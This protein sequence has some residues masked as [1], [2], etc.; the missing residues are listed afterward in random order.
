MV[1]LANLWV[2][3]PCVGSGMALTTSLHGGGFQAPSP[4][5]GEG[6]GFAPSPCPQLGPQHPYLKQIGVHDNGKPRLVSQL[7]RACSLQRP[8]VFP[9]DPKISCS[10]IPSKIS[11]FPT[12][13]LEKPSTETGL[14]GQQ[15][16][17]SD[18]CS[19]PLPV[20]EYMPIIAH[21]ILR[22]ISLEQRVTA[23]DPARFVP[24]KRRLIGRAY[25]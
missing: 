12:D 23:S 3:H 11:L 22:K 14:V 16:F 15:R 7:P 6:T 25:D 8:T 24:A 5:P 19:D 10:E 20:P 13:R 1:P 2:T 17:Q 18:G 4:C 9:E 21:Q